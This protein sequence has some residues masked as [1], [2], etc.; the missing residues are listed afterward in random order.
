ML[1]SPVEDITS[2][3][4]ALTARGTKVVLVYSP[5]VE[6]TFSSVSVDDFYDVHLATKYLWGIGR[7]SIAFVVG[8]QPFRQA[9]DRL[10]GNMR[11]VAEFPDTTLEVLQASDPTLLDGRCG[12]G[13]A[14]TCRE[15]G[16]RRRG[17]SERMI[18]WRCA[19]CSRSPWCTLCESP[20]TWHS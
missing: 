16:L 1:I 5:A 2:L 10:T 15:Q 6:G 13:N 12:I 8:S 14:F 3:L 19:S 7:R 18:C 17:Y 11:A 9:T 20:R 4:K